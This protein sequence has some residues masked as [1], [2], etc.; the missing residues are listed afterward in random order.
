MNYDELT[1]RYPEV[2]L[3]DPKDP[4][5]I[6]EYAQS[7][8][9]VDSNER[10]VR[11]EKPGDGNMN[12]T[13]RLITTARSIILKQS[14]PWVEKYPQIE[15][16]WDRV[17]REGRFYSLVG[18]S[19]SLRQRMPAALDLDPVSRI[20]V[21]SDLGP[22]TD[23]T[24]LYRGVNL[25]TDEANDLSAWLT[26]LHQLE[27][28]AEDRGSLTN[29][30][31]RALNHEHI[32]RFPLLADNGLNL[33]DITP[34]LQAQ[35]NQL[36]VNRRFVDAISGLGQRYLEDGPTLLHGDYFPGSWLRTE[37][38]IHVIDPEFGFF[39]CAE[40][41]AGVFFAHLTIAENNDLRA[42]RILEKYVPPNDFDCRLMKQFAGTEIMR[43]LI[44]VAQLPLDYDLQTKT[45]LLERSRQLVLDP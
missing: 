40:F 21:C 5:R 41:D 44:G 3:L 28:S 15:A 35:A 37:N 42:D 7:R 27:F 1:A 20:F 4:A 34:G 12:Y 13:V 38:G 26:T 18:K 14:R 23:L 39:G 24:D 9:L 36:I 6:F 11:I 32:F 45:A 10:L 17:I 43:R 30:D 19:D 31:M 8:R 33:D 22:A 25:D 29:R 2:T 16:P